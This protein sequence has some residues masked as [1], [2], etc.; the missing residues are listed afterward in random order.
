MPDPYDIVPETNPKTAG[1]G[2]GVPVGKPVDAAGSSAV[3]PSAS[4]QPAPSPTA[5]AV[6]RSGPVLEDAKGEVA[7]EFCTPRTPGVQVLLYFGAFMLVAAMIASGANGY[8]FWG[9][10]G[11]IVLTVWQSVV[12]TGTGV[13]AVA[14]AAWLVQQRFG[15][16]EFAVARM[17]VAFTTFSFIMQLQIPPPVVGEVLKVVLAGLVYWTGV[18]V[19]FGKSPRETSL[20]AM[21]HAGA[22]LFVEFGIRLAMWLPTG[23]TGG[24]GGG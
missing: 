5:A 3:P 17:F 1:S 23:P 6:P 12:H 22:W 11:R 19:L 7:P 18:L 20:V 8:G 10:I 4:Q 9:S 14:L 13:A 24:G 15:N 2:A 21:A 16:V